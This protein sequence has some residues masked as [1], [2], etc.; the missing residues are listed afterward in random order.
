MFLKMDGHKIFSDYFKEH[1]RMA[2]VCE[3]IVFTKE[4][5]TADISLPWKLTNIWQKLFK[6]MLHLKYQPYL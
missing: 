4:S 1:L 2:V 5:L 3:R 6:A